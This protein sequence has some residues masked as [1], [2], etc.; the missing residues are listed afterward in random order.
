MLSASIVGLQHAVAHMCQTGGQRAKCGP[1]S[2]NF[3]PQPTQLFCNSSGLYLCLRANDGLCH[4]IT[5][6]F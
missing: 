1:R 2:L 5:L 4:V 3:K 6:L